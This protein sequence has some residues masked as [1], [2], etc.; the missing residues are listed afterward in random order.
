[1]CKIMICVFK[2]LTLVGRYLILQTMVMRILFYLLWSDIETM[3][4]LRE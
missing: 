2:L 3:L 4:L 1:M